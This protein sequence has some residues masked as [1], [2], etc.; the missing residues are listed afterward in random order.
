ME[1]NASSCVPF[2][3]SVCDENTVVFLALCTLPTDRFIRQSFDYHIHM[4]Y[5]MILRTGN[6]ISIFYSNE[7][8]QICMPSP[9]ISISIVSLPDFHAVL[10]D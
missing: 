7:W 9:K 5:C 4:C 1:L 8:P 6:N 10:I 2:V 3:P